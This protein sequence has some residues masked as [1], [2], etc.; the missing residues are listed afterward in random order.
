[1]QVQARRGCFR[2]APLKLGGAGE[3]GWLP[4]AYC[5]P[6]AADFRAGENNLEQLC[7]KVALLQQAVNHQ[8]RDQPD[9]CQCNRWACCFRCAHVLCAILLM[10]SP[11]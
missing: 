10:L 7:H 4:V 9:R 2:K 8:L 11:M 5:T 3:W 6:H 1:M